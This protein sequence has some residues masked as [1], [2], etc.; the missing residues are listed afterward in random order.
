MRTEVRRT[1]SR[2]R[3]MLLLA[4]L[5]SLAGCAT[6]RQD[7]NAVT[8]LGVVESRIEDVPP[9]LGGFGL[10]LGLFGLFSRGVG[11]GVGMSMPVPT[12]SAGGYTRYVV[13]LADGG[14]IAFQ[15]RNPGLRIGDCVRVW[16]VGD[17]S[18]GTPLT[19]QQ[20]DLDLSNECPAAPSQTWGER[21][22]R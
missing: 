20:G 1:S 8:T 14:R 15:S 18:G 11:V 19:P 21:Y 10:G 3:S 13:A 16:Y 22:S 12:Q 7:P 6:V 17:A 5:A 9:T 4:L 2:G